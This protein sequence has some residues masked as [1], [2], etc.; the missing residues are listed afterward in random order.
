VKCSRA[1]SLAVKSPHMFLIFHT[2]HMFWSSYPLSFNRPNSISCISA[3]LE[4][5]N[6]ILSS[7]FSDSL[8]VS[9]HCAVSDIRTCI[10]M[11]GLHF[12]IWLLRKEVSMSAL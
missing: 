3:K 9:L 4:L 11:V 7:V 1:L 12:S 2:F 6:I 10:L 5:S 8:H